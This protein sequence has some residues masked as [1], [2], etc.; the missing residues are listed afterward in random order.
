MLCFFPKFDER[1]F[2]FGIEN[3]LYSPSFVFSF[4]QIFRSIHA[5]ILLS[6]DD[7]K[8]FKGFT[9]VFFNGVIVFQLTLCVKQ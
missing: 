6:A 7:H 9:T 3:C 2:I 1:N 4:I 8:V 5:L